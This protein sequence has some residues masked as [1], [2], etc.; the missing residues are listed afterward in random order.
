[1]PESASSQIRIIEEEE[2]TIDGQLVDIR[3]EARAH[4]A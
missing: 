3:A 2:K 4:F 1:V